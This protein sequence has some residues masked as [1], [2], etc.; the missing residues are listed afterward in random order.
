MTSA[1][2]FCALFALNPRSPHTSRGNIRVAFWR[3]ARARGRVDRSSIL[4]IFWHCGDRH[5][6]SRKPRSGFP[7]T[8]RQRFWPRIPRSLGSGNADSQ[9]KGWSSGWSGRG[10][11]CTCDP[12][13]VRAHPPYWRAAASYRPLRAV[14]AVCAWALRGCARTPKPFSAQ[15]CS[16]PTH[17]ESWL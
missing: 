9:R 14:W 2:I 15:E 11:P 10:R 6:S 8:N 16:A 5:F 3:C 1:E 13:C 12:G 4:T 7:A 17:K